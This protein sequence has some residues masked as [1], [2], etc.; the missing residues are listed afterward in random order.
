V[1]ALPKSL[2]HWSHQSE[3]KRLFLIAALFLVFMLVFS[4]HRHYTF[5]SS[6]DHGLFNQLFWNN[7]HGHFFQSSLTGAN[8]VG[9]L[10]DHKI[11]SESFLHLGQHFVID[12]LLWL[13]LYAL[14]PSPVTLIVLQ[15]G[16]MTAGG[17]V[18][19]ALARHYLS[20]NLSLLITAGY[21]S[22]NAVIGPTFANF[23]EQCQIPLFAF[24]LL[25]AMEKRCWW[26]FWLLVVAVLGIRE[27]AGFI[28]FGVGLYLLVSRRHPLI[29]SSLCLLSFAYV[30]LIT[31]GVMPHFSDDSSRLYLSNR[32]SQYVQGNPSPSTLDVL[33]GIA[34][35]PKELFT[36]L[37]TPF[38]TK[39]VYLLRQWLPLAFIPAIAPASWLTAGVPLLSLIVQ[40]G[41]SALTISLRYSVAVVPG[42]FYGAILWWSTHRSQ[43]TPRFRRIWIGCIALSLVVAIAS[44]PNRAFSFLIP[45]SFVPWVYVPLQRQWQH[46]SQIQNLIRV[47]PPDASVSATTFI[48]PHL[49]SRRE[50]IRLPALALKTD[51]GQI[52][53]MDYLV[54]DLWR[55]QQ[56]QAAFRDDRNNLRGLIATLDQ[57]L[58]QS[59]Y[60]ILAVQDGVVL[61]QRAV[62]SNPEAL[63]AWV[64][65]RQELSTSLPT[66]DRK[67]N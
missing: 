56:Y 18:L 42:L 64:H 34:S 60:G 66:G 14:F 47:I 35:H 53:E 67:Q 27:E 24:G 59:R 26:M 2:I 11:P 45:D 3:A 43:L 8:S 46:A 38:G 30:V 40:D 1:I 7:L 15:V 28:T 10:E 65:L 22:S 51:Q 52:V 61:L 32:F 29:G 21:Y 37:L 44:N 9:V 20:P 36:S 13:P 19:Y 16:L 33:W 17:L 25:L 58:S 49:S 57:I 5:Y 62:S 55:L 12:F 39:L 31:N 48:I 23:Y 50:I 6:Y 63:N 54:A 41:Q 4:L